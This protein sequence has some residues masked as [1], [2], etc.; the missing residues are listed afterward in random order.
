MS[1]KEE[2]GKMHTCCFWHYVSNISLYIHVS[3]SLVL[4]EWKLKREGEYA[5]KVSDAL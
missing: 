1:L 4:S 5:V 2:Q 3:M